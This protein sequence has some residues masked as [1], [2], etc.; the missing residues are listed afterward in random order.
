MFKHFKS[1]YILIFLISL[2]LFNLSKPFPFLRRL[3]TKTLEFIKATDLIYLNSKWQFNIRYSSDN[4]LSIGTEL[5]TSILYKGEKAKADC[6]V[7]SSDKLECIY[8]GSNQAKS[9]LI[10]L[11][12]DSSVDATIKWSNLDTAKSIP[13]NDT[14]TF[15]DS[16]FS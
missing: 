15:E 6:K 8:N 16:F 11:K 5:T 7:T 12:Y 10:Q 4:D 1:Y 3:Q 2:S 9:D 14:L 13:M